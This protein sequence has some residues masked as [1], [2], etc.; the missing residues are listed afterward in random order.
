MIDDGCTGARFRESGCRVKP[1]S[2]FVGE[3][4]ADFFL[5]HYGVCAFERTENNRDSTADIWQG[6][7]TRRKKPWRPCRVSLQKNKILRG[8]LGERA[9]NI[10]NRAISR[11]RNRIDTTGQHTPIGNEFAVAGNEETMA[12]CT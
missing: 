3:A 12:V 5:E 9:R 10:V 2:C 4:S 1:F 11:F 8:R 7:R 6:R